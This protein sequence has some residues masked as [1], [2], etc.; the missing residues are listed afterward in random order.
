M[1]TV[2]ISLP[3]AAVVQEFVNRISPLDGHFDFLS[4]GYILDAKSLMGIFTL[5][6]TKPLTL[7]IEKDTHETMEA[8]GRYIVEDL[9]G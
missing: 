2:T 3:R 5:N 8:I 4:E 9:H 1:K 6:L 7:R